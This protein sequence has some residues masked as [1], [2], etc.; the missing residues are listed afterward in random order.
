MLNVPWIEYKLFINKGQ[1]IFWIL[2]CI[3][4]PN[5]TLKVI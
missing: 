2:L 5:Q 3:V 4:S 1:P